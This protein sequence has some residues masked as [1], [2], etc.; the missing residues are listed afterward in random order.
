MVNEEPLAEAQVP[1]VPATPQ[2]L[3]LGAAAE[4]LIASRIALLGYQVYRPLADDRGVDLLV[5]VGDGR[6]VA[7]QVKAVRHTTS[8][9]VFMRKSTFAL[10]PWTV[11]ALVVYGNSLDDQPQVY[12]VPATEWRSPRPPLTNYDYVGGKSS[13]EYGLNIRKAWT[14]ELA[15]WSA[16]SDHI[17]RLMQHA[18]PELT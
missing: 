12:F 13:P 15:E 5:D 16:D 9:Y 7:V 18:H 2:K 11:L 8:S 6:H 17:H 14:D 1:K 4:L 10:E 3:A